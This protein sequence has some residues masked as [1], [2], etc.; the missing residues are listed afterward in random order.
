VATTL[1]RPSYSFSSLVLALLI[2]I[3]GV[4]VGVEYADRNLN[5]GELS[6][7][8]VARRRRSRTSCRP[9]GG[10]RKNTIRRPLRRR[11]ARGGR[12]VLNPLP[13]RSVFLSRRRDRS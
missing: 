3:F 11:P 2:A 12:P 1:I 4:L 7:H 5:G 10:S 13:R 6:V 8:R 9:C